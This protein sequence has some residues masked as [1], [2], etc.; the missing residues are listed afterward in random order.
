MGHIDALKTVVVRNRSHVVEEVVE[1]AI[2]IDLTVYLVVAVRP[3]VQVALR[4]ELL[5]GRLRMAWV[6]EV[7][8]SHPMGG[9]EARAAEAFWKVPVRLAGEAVA[10]VQLLCVP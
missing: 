7:E 9:D 3:V 1:E 5:P 10:G 2:R 6:E 4:V 8:E